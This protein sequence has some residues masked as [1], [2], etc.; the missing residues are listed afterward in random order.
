MMHNLL[1]ILLLVLLEG[2]CACGGDA[3][4][5]DHVV[6]PRGEQVDFGA[7]L[8]ARMEEAS[9]QRE[10]AALEFSRQYRERT[11]R[12][13]RES[14]QLRDTMLAFGLVKSPWIRTD[15]LR[16][17]YKGHVTL[18][19]D[20]IQRAL[21]PFKDEPLVSVELDAYLIAAIAWH[22]SSWADAVIR[23]ER[24]GP[25]GEIGLVQ[26]LPGGVCAR[27]PTEEGRAP[28]LLDTVE[29]VQAGIRCLRMIRDDMYGGEG[30]VW[31]WLASYASGK[32]WPDGWASVEG[33]TGFRGVYRALLQLRDRPVG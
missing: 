22:E 20:A 6:R 25:R 11:E 27:I 24:R 8:R 4:A 12:A 3:A 31:R 26:I 7:S 19:A 18:V 30:D 16:R 13:E 23:G 14:R 9:R 21:V 17:E 15:Q 33:P 2:G 28:N 29:N 10:A 5:D 32:L 1:L